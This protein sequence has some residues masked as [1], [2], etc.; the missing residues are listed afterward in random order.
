[1]AVDEHL[2]SD[3]SSGA[4]RLP[5]WVACVA[6]T[7]V[8]LAL[9]N[10]GVMPSAT[11]SVTPLAFHIT[12]VDILLDAGISLL[13]FGCVILIAML[14]ALGFGTMAAKS[15]AL[16]AVL[17]PFLWCLGCVPALGTTAVLYV[18]LPAGASPNVAEWMVVA[19]AVLCFVPLASKALHNA[20]VTTP[21]DLLNV[22]RCLGL[23]RWA[24]FW[25]VEMP[26]ALP[27]FSSAF[28]RQIPAA[29]TVMLASEML[30]SQGPPQGGSS[31]EVTSH[32]GLGAAALAVATEGSAVSNTEIFVVALIMG[33]VLDR[34]LAQPLKTWT[35]RYAVS[36][37]RRSGAM[38]LMLVSWS[39]YWPFPN[40]SRKLIDALYECLSWLGTMPLGR[41]PRA[42]PADS[43]I[44]SPPAWW[45][46]FFWVFVGV[47]ALLM[48]QRDG[49]PHMAGAGFQILEETL[50]SLFFVTLIGALFAVPGILIGVWGRHVLGRRAATLSSLLMTLPAIVL[51]PL[52][53]RLAD[54]GR[55]A[56]TFWIAVLLMPGVV[57]LVATECLVAMRN[58]PAD[59]FHAARYLGLRGQ[60]LWERLLWPTLSPYLVRGLRESFEWAWNMLVLIESFAW[61]GGL[62]AMPGI[63]AYVAVHAL[64]QDATVTVLGVAAMTMVTMAMRQY[65]WLP[66]RLRVELRYAIPDQG[67]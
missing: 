29:L 63:G 37:Q 31:H 33:V 38:R 17:L 24:Q 53:A 14:A 39:A 46:S 1:M 54:P 47:V 55:A 61:A 20:L 26:H 8:L 15:S 44:R 2:S 43:E 36:G 50:F 41:P 10:R 40:L 23:R 51:F 56:S 28:L 3:T 62:V 6:V 60:L 34:F 16:S 35:Q 4:S 58:M 32:E 64:R 67:S 9:A 12:F 19:S 59:R 25:R 45:S 42:A 5:R 11:R 30:V 21:S 13:R 57:G 65:L 48:S 52:L 27:A 49:T 7:L 22:A 18:M 66:L